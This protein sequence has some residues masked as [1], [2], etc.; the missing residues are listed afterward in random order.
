MSEKDKHK[1]NLNKQPGKTYVSPRFEHGHGPERQASKAI[2]SMTNFSFNIEEGR[3]VLRETEG[4]RHVVEVRFFETDR[5]IK[6]I[7][8]Q[9]Y[10]TATGRPHPTASLSFWGDQIP[11]LIEFLLNIKRIHFP[12]SEKVNITDA[13]LRQILLS[14]EQLDRLAVEDQE[15]LIALAH[16]KITKRDVV[17]MAYRREQLDEFAKLL[18][19]DAYFT[20]A[21]TTTKEAVWQAFLERNHWIFGYGLT[22]TSLSA[23]DGRRL[24]QIVSGAS[25]AAPGKRPDALMKS[26][27]AVNALCFAEIKTHQTPL[28]QRDRYRSGTWQPSSE[29]TGGISQS[30][31]TVHAALKQIGDRLDVTRD[32]DPTG[33]RVYS[34]DPRSY[35]VIGRLSDFMAEHGLNEDKYRSFEFFRRNVRRP[36]IITFDELYE[37]AALIVAEHDQRR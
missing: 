30:H 5:Q 1:V 25:I 11:R 34:F 10:T 2:D 13:E 29:L 4:G 6:G 17:A 36:E 32:G 15:S 21:I 22:Y 9:K 31:A 28:L 3:V 8:I 7:T 37:R 23:L 16:G 33:E 24:E 35:L 14:S 12:S 26:R 20:A 27:G 18:S 19:D